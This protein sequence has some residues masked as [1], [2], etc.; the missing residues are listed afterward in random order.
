MWAAGIVLALKWRNHCF[1]RL[2]HHYSHRHLYCG[3]EVGLG[4]GHTVLDRDSAPL[5]RK[6]HSSPLFS[7]HI[8]CGQ[9]VAHLSNCWALALLFSSRHVGRGKCY[10][11]RSTV[12]SYHT[13][14]QSLFVT[15][16]SWRTASR[17]WF[18]TAARL[19]DIA[20]ALISDLVNNKCMLNRCLEWYK[21]VSAKSV[22]VCRS[23]RK[24]SCSSFW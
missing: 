2:R 5:P 16:W 19:A 22:D 23:F 11:L 8:Y 6:W 9:T 17:S 12:A 7:P 4:L 13:Q 14:R 10:G 20:T 3:M 1:R 21:W 15:P 24:Q 18:A